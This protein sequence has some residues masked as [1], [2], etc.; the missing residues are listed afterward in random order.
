M[1]LDLIGIGGIFGADVL[2]AMRLNLGGHPEVD[3]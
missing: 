2:W 3:G 1:R